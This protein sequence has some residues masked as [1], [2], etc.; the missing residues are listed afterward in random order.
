MS[1]PEK[2]YNQTI[3]NFLRSYYTLELYERED[4]FQELLKER[5]E[6]VSMEQST[7]QAPEIS[8]QQPSSKSPIA[9][10]NLRRFEKVEIFQNPSGTLALEFVPKSQMDK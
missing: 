3:V 1:E 4:I 8:V 7:P 10:L 5:G 6:K 2:P 9:V